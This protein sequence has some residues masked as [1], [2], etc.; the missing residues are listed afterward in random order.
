MIQTCTQCPAKFEIT[1]DDLAFYHKVSPKIGGQVY[2]VPPPSLCPECRVQRRMA[3][4][5]DRTFYHRKCDL[6][7]KQFISMYPSDTKFPVYKQDVWHGDGWDGMDFGQDFDE[8][9]SFFQP[10]QHPYP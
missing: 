1:D 8:S 9:K 3:W 10:H 2:L 4:R 6:S 7:G 5:N